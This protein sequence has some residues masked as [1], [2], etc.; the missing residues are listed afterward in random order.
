[1]SQRSLGLTWLD[2]ND[3][4]QQKWAHQYLQ[5]KGEIDHKYDSS[6]IDQ[7]LR[8]GEKLEDS[9]NGIL[10]IGQMRD[11]WRR[12]KS[13]ASD[14]DKD[15]KTYAFKLKTDVKKE[16]ARLAK[17]S[18]VTAADMLGR[19]ISGELDAHVRFETKLN[20]EKKT[21][22]ELLRN[23]RN[24]TAQ[25]RETNRTLR[26]L[27]DVSIARLCRSE[28]LLEDAALSTRS[29][30]EDQQR[31]IE[32]LRKQTMANAVAVV[33]GQ[34]A[35]V[36]R[37]LFNHA[38]PEVDSTQAQTVTAAGSQF[39]SQHLPTSTDYEPRADAEN[40]P[41]PE[42]HPEPGLAPTTAP[43]DQA[44]DNHKGLN[45]EKFPG[46]KNSDSLVQDV[47]NLESRSAI[48]SQPGSEAPSDIPNRSKK[49]TFQKSPS[50]HRL[51]RRKPEENTP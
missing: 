47:L 15:R 24:N 12:V 50:L 32:E 7:L 25:Y 44:L 28:I 39:C 1:M 38:K 17:K 43:H 31:R 6:T 13:N 40:L 18:N 5:K 37:E 19:L 4:K 30:T 3:H 20:E 48:Q 2:R 8:I 26:E 10:I 33:K 45:Q 41:L 9:K 46:E 22:K 11:A 35:L 14:K 36:P 34:S 49:I 27:L 42:A 21:Y 23:S 51:S 16:L 29:I